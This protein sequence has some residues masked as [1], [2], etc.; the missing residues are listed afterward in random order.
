MLARLRCCSEDTTNAAGGTTSGA[1]AA[2]AVPTHKSSGPSGRRGWLGEER[3]AGKTILLH[4]EQ[5][6]GD[7]LQFC[8]YIG[9]VAELGARVILEV[10]EPLIR[11]LAQLPGVSRLIAKGSD[12]PHVD[13]HRPLMS[14]P[15]ALGA[16]S[17]I[18]APVRFRA[19]PTSVERWR[20]RLLPGRPRVGL[21]FSGSTIHP[22]DRHRSISLADWIPHLPSDFQYVTLQKDVRP[23][24]REVLRAHP[25]ITCFADELEDFADTAALC[26]VLDH[27]IC[28]DTS[29]AHLSG[30]MGVRTWVLLPF[31]PDWRWLLGRSDSPWY[32]SV[33]LYRQGSIGVWGNV[34]AQ[35]GA[36][37]RRVPG[38]ARR[39]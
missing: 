14:L 25:Y 23:A 8:R 34:L 22:N 18:P 37:L 31:N 15:L 4:A 19:E 30:S 26:E 32:P 39:D 9:A 35:V 16:A 12:L 11:L 2:R 17:S 5:G 13:Y 28:V 20:S 29:I 24:D 27:V 3:L 6:L 21:V 36:G 33:T 10:H 38:D 7:S 1:G